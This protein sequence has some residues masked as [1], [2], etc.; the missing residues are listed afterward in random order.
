MTTRIRVLLVDDHAVLREGL[1]LLVHAQSDME[2]VGEAQSGEEAVECARTLRPDLVL[3]DLAMPGVGGIEATARIRRESPATRVVAL[4]MYDDPAYLRSVLAAGASGYVLKRAASTELLSA[5]RTAH[6]GETYLAPSLAG[7]VVDELLGRKAGNADTPVAGDTLSD[8]EREVLRLVA[9]GHTNQQVAEQ[10]RLSVKTVETYRAR[11]ME[12][13]G[14][15]S[16][17]DLVRY[18]VSSGFLKPR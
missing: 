6:R 7:G 3:M 18:A 2:V 9:E 17:V 5:I 15:K 14:L 16:R 4:T 8:R 13:L 12:K 10:L 1:R 11:L